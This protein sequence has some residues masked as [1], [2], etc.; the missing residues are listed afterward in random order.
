[1]ETTGDA[2]TVQLAPNR[3]TINADGEDVSVFTV[4]ATDARGRAVPVADNK[5]NFTLSGAGHILGVGNGDPSC[6]EPDTYVP[7]LPL[8]ATAD[9]NWSW[10]LTED[11]SK[12]LSNPEDGDY[13]ADFDD[14]SWDRTSSEGDN[15]QLS[16]GQSAIFRQHLNITT[17]E[18]A[19]L[20]VQLHFGRIDDN[21]WVFVN[22]QR[23][24]ESRDWQSSPTFDIKK[25]LHPGDNVVAVGVHNAEGSGGLTMG[26]SL[27]L[28]SAP[29]APAWS[30]SLFN[31]LAEVIVQSTKE[32]GDIQLTASADGLVPAT[33]T[34]QSQAV[35]LRPSVP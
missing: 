11:T 10:K 19:G 18:L 33:S 21:G 29:V 27:E 25:Y 31:G 2:A 26:V 17:D 23:V 22:G 35:K 30:R 32:A 24:G 13:A 5:I 14:S 7:E 16:E 8:K 3:T 28:V 6:H 15:S 4:S 34:I 20:G 12:N 9:N 1:V